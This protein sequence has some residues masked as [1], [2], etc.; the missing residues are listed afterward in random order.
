MQKT[1]SGELSLYLYRSTPRG[2]VTATSKPLD[3]LAW[4]HFKSR[5]EARKV[6]MPNFHMA[7]A[8]LKGTEE[9]YRSLGLGWP[10]D[11]HLA[12]TLSGDNDEHGQVLSV[13]GW[14]CR[15]DLQTGAFDVP[16][17]FAEHNARAIAP[18]AK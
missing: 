13:R 11:R 1:G 4:D 17:E 7:V 9:N 14:R 15:Y 2:F 10:K 5:P 12:L 16:P 18:E 3:A 8:P 6:L